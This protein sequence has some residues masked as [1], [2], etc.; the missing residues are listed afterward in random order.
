M[1]EPEFPHATEQPAEVGQVQRR[2]RPRFVALP[3]SKGYYLHV[4]DLSLPERMSQPEPWWHET[5]EAAEAAAISMAER[6]N[7]AVFVLA[8]V[9]K[10]VPWHQDSPQGPNAKLTG[11]QRDDHE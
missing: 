11:S 1:T 5:R 4:P 7:W 6:T 9:S 2:V 3:G 8:M 10:V